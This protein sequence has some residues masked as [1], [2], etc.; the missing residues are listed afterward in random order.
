MDSCGM[1]ILVEMEEITVPEVK[2]G[3]L[4]GRNVSVPMDRFGTDIPAE[5]ET[6][7]P[8]DRSGTPN[9]INVFV[10]MVLNGTDTPAS[11]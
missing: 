4:F 8:E 9:G 10:L 2:F 1:G 6:I 3:N 5:M 11:F 7:V